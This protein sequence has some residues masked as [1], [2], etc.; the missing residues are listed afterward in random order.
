MNKWNQGFTFLEILIAMVI[1]GILSI[2]AYPS[3]MEYIQKAR[4]SDAQA[5]LSQDQLIMERCYSQNFS[6]SAACGARPTF[7]QVTPE[8]FYTINIS[9]LTATTYTLTATPRGAQLKDTKCATM[10]VNQAN[11]KTAADSGAASQTECWNPH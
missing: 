11:V 4:R 6:Y 5:I 2:I 10:S 1:I 9:N 7:P 8:G 3:Y